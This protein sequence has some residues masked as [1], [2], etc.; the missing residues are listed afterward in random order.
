MLCYFRKLIFI[1][2]NDL[3]GSSFD[4]QIRKIEKR[5]SYSIDTKEIIFNAAPFDIICR[6]QNRK[7]LL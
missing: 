3:H 1:K 4:I 5:P 7:K 2:I 6:Y